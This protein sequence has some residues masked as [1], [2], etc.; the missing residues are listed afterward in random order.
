MKDKLGQSHVIQGRL[1]EKMIELE[2][3]LDIELVLIA[4]K[5]KAP[6]LSL[7][8]DRSELVISKFLFVH[9]FDENVNKSLKSKVLGSAIESIHNHLHKPLLNMQMEAY[10]WIFGM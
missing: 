2:A 3:K 10:S 9:N 5:A 7:V 1:T 6:V 8:C 4:R